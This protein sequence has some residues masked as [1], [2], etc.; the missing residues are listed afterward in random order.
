MNLDDYDTTLDDARRRLDDAR[1]NFN[2]ALF[3]RDADKPAAWAHMPLVR[4]ELEEAERGY[5][6]AY[7]ARVEALSVMGRRY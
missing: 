6:L 3:N 1:G 7:M 5:A 2:R 4:A